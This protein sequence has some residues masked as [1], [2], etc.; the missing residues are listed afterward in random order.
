M[1]LLQ[2]KKISTFFCFF[3]FIYLV[4][5]LGM[6]PLARRE[7]WDLLA[8]L[9]HGRSMLL[10]THYM[11][12]ADVLGDRIG[13]MSLG[14]MQCCGTPHFLKT[15]LG[16]GY[17]LIFDKTASMSDNQV[18]ALTQYVN[19]FIPE[20]AFKEEIGQDTIITF[21]LPFNAVGK[22]GKFF[23]S[24]EKDLPSLA[25][26]GFNLTITTLED[27]FLK[28]GEDHTVTPHSDA[29]NIGI[30]AR[31]YQ[32]TFFSQV[33]GI[34]GRRLLYATHDFLTFVLLILPLAG[35]IVAA[36]LYKNNVIS[37]DKQ[38]SDMAST[39]ITIAGYIGA[40]GM[41]AEFLVR[42]RSDKLRN[43]L[44]VMGCSYPAYWVGSFIADYILMAITLGVMF[45]SWGAADIEHFYGSDGGLNFF[46]WI[47]FVFEMVSFSYACSFMFTSPKSCIWTMPVLVLLLLIMPNILLLIGLQIAK[48]VGT[49][50]KSSDQGKKL[51]ILLERIHLN[52][53]FFSFLAGIL[54]WGM[55]FLSPYGAVFCACL[56][57]VNNFSDII[58]S[59]PNVGACIAIM[60]I[61]SALFLA[62][63][64][65]T[66]IQS[67]IPLQALTDP[68]TDE[69]ALE[70][71]DEDVKAE[72]RRTLENKEVV[73]IE[74][75]VNPD[76]TPP[77]TM[78]RLR[79]FFPPK[80]Q[81]RRGVMAVEDLALTVDKG[82]IFG[83]L[84]AN[85][86]GKTTAL[87]LLTRL[88]VPTSGDA[89]LAGHSILS[90]FTKAATHLGVVTQ[91]N[92]LWDKLSV[93]DH[94]YLFARLRGVPED[95]VKQVVS[96]TIDQL[97]L[98][99]HRKKLAMN[100]SGGMK[101]KLC[102]AIALIGDPEVVLLDEPSAGLDP[103]SRRNLWTVILRTMSN[104]S[105]ILTTHSMEEAEALCRRIGIMVQGQVRALGSKLHLKNKYGSGFELTVKL[106]A[107]DFEKEID[108]LGKFV[109]S[110]F[111]SA[112]VLAQNGGLVTYQIPKEE[113][114]M[115]VAFEQLHAKREALCIEE[116]TVAQPTLEQVRH[117][118]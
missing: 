117:S 64:Y 73:G 86:A 42:E 110:L 16:A 55:V 32:T 28:V 24:L 98:T 52:L 13:I 49:S 111:P 68:T 9:R 20:A 72:R 95:L 8:S 14:K 33:I 61:E 60:I 100:L 1:N 77:L 51:L 85:G 29:N 19:K 43:V 106:Q 107:I 53:L 34:I 59:L 58:T 113:M 71:L 70:L 82:E 38:I 5:S 104:R 67:S 93:E 101:R 89:F 103:V 66:D 75:G 22:F 80:V 17:R 2:V 88:L 54:L 109:T 69:A 56:N 47:L 31:T 26:T 118:R 4:F 65:Y 112:F 114:K 57:V 74:G 63:T 92:S 25:V 97:E 105:V 46:L 48:A 76:V 12:E 116:F 15:T 23:Q 91:N 78:K 7:L 87:S 108:E 99:P 3:I 21:T 6:D 102:V 27:V 40:P 79:K 115:S 10:T 84:G 90:D 44:N 36:I 45:I 35:I 83:L 30:G 41:I 62:F 37:S 39:G 94:L 50:I 11:D 81:G 96:G 18:G